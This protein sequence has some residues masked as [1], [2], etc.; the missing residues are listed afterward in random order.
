MDKES[1]INLIILLLS[2]VGLVAGIFWLDNYMKVHK[3]DNPYKQVCVKSHTT[4]RVVPVF[5]TINGRTQ[6]QMRPAIIRECD[7]YETVLKDGCSDN[8]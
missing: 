2:C 4:T 8:K 3:C 1:L 7:E 6:T 5:V